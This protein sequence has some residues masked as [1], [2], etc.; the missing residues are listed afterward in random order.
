MATATANT[1]RYA[2]LSDHG[3]IRLLRLIPHQDKLAPIQCHLFEYPLRSLGHH[4][5]HLYEALSYVWGSGTHSLPL[6]IQPPLPTGGVR[7]SGIGDIRCLHI[8]KN[9]HTALI[10]I[11]DPYFDR[12]L[13]IDAVCINQQDN[14][15]KGRQVQSMAKI[16]ASASRVVVWLGPGTMDTAGAF[17]ALCKAASKKP[18]STKVR[19][20]I[21]ALLR[22]PWFQRIWVGAIGCR[23][24]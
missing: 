23:A 13:W 14:A 20:A 21:P 4:T 2:P 24:K 10:H 6:Y 8:T 17:E 18:V 11:R 1:Y 16:Y 7:E 12:V 5:A 3:N 9:L 19:D 22:R 15:E